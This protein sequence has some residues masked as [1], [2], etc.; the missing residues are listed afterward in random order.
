MNATSQ[1]HRLAASP[2]NALRTPQAIQRAINGLPAHAAV[3][4]GTGSIVAVNEAWRRF[5]RENGLSSETGGVGTSYLRVCESS[6]ARCTEGPVVARAIRRVLNGSDSAFRRG[7]ACHGPDRIAWFQVE[8]ASLSH[9]GS[10]GVLVTHARVDEAVIRREIADAE[11]RHIARELHDTTAQ[12]LTSALFDLEN[13]AKAQLATTGSVTPDLSEAIELCQRSLG[14]VRCLAYEVAPPGFRPDRLVESLNKLATNFARRTGFAVTLLSA[15]LSIGNDDLTRECSEALYRAA[16]ESL[17]NARRHSG[18]HRV[19]IRIN[20]SQGGLRLEVS[21]DGRG[22]APDAQPG[23][24]LCDIR[25]R[26][27]AC[28][29]RMELSAATGGT[30][31]VASVPVCGGWDALDCDPR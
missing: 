8:I 20:R 24:G 4:D 5:G 30:V 28:G 3:L 16:A 14:E 22:I 29:G 17:Q 13:V 15:P 11:R 27:E 2:G 9:R 1:H 19:S 18:G 23:K 25:D 7:Y 6:Q 12:N 26:I 31:L 21:D 10:R